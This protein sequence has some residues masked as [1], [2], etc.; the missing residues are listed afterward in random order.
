M[1][2]FQFLKV[3]R[4][5][6]GRV[7]TIEFQRPAKRNAFNRAMSFEMRTAFEEVR[8][9][10]TADVLVLRGAGGHYSAGDD[11][12]EFP[13]GG[14]FRKKGN[15][16]MER[17]LGGLR[18]V[19]MYQDTA[20][21]IEEMDKVVVSVVDGNCIGGGLELSMVSDIV[22]ATPRSTFGIPEIDIDITPGWGGTSRLSRFAGRHKVKEMVL[23]GT[24]I[25][26]DEALRMGLVNRVVPSEQL[27][28]ELTKVIDVLLSKRPITLK[29]MK[30]ITNKGLE[31]TVEGALA[32]EAISGLVCWATGEGE[33]PA[34]PATRDFGT[35]SGAWKSRRDLV[36]RLKW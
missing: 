14:L 20:N 30:F 33:P 24:L 12:S 9:D 19:T 8:L 29:L 21:T 27:D 31:T 25:G 11:I 3:T 34:P 13:G 6:D 4:T 32:Y 2:E 1:A 22:L 36:A 23:L 16:V 5:Q 7:V 15:S 18:T 35:K 28:A 17:A 10:T 26:A